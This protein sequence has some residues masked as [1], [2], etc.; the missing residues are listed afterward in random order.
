MI[1]I[2]SIR[3]L[4]PTAT[5]FLILAASGAVLADDINSGPGVPPVI[6]SDD[7]LNV[8]TSLVLI[9]AII[10]VVGFSYTRARGVRGQGGEIIRVLATQSLGPKERVL[11][12]EVGGTQ[13]V[14]GMTTSQIQ[15]LHVLDQ[16]L[17]I[18]ARAPMAANFAERLR[19]A[20]KGTRK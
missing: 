19:S 6:G 8:G 9:V 7:V 20:I 17:D 15:T 10:F 2:N 12:V 18:A 3:N 13:L 14:I 1:M 11:L 16:P 4:A 5:V